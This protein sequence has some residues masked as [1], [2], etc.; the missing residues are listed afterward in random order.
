MSNLSRKKMGINDDLLISK[1]IKELR[2]KRK[3]TQAQAAK[4]V[5]VDSNTWSRYERGLVIPSYKV[6]GKIVEIFNIDA[7]WLLTGKEP[8][9][10]PSLTLEQK[11][12]LGILNQ[13]PPHIQQMIFKTFHLLLT[14]YFEK[15]IKAPK[16][17]R[18]EEVEKLQEII[19]ILS[20]RK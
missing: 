15:Y 6:L 12:I 7:Y 13:Y 16:E 10:I 3:L 18:I 4:T 9:G 17:R 20:I 2:K 14:N 1:R 8:K 5:G 11:Q 19:R